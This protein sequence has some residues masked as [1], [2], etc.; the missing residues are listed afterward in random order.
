MANLVDADIIFE[1]VVTQFVELR[2]GLQ[3]QRAKTLVARPDKQG[4]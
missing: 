3:D 2:E 1:H 4:L